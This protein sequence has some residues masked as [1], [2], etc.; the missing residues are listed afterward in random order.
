[1]PRGLI[2][3]LTGKVAL[4]FPA[5]DHQACVNLS[6]EVGLSSN[7]PELLTKPIKRKAK[8]YLEGRPDAAFE[9]LEPTDDDRS[10]FSLYCDSV[11]IL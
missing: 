5:L 9:G 2:T 7:D 3:K 1:M 4:T 11:V 8:K 10:P 6:A